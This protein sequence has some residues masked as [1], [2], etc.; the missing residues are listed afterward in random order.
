MQVDISTVRKEAENGRKTSKKGKGGETHPYT[1]SSPTPFVTSSTSPFPSSAPS[2]AASLLHLRPLTLHRL[3]PGRFLPR[4]LINT[5]IQ[6]THRLL[7]DLELG[8]RCGIV[9]EALESLHRA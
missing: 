3:P 6:A 1:S 7:L 9:A 2:S 8:A 5:D 4:F